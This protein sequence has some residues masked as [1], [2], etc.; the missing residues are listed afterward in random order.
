MKK[1]VIVIPTYNECKPIQGLLS[2]I[3]RLLPEV[4]VIVVDDNSPDKT[5]EKVKSLLVKYKH[6]HLISRKGKGGR[7][8]AVMT[9]FKHA[10]KHFKPD[11]YIEMDA[12]FSHEPKEIKNIISLSKENAVV[13]ASRYL[14]GSK[15]I[16]WPIKRHLAS[17]ISNLLVRLVLKLPLRDNTNGYRCYQRKAI[18]ILLGHQF[19]NQG[20]MVLSESAYLLYQ[21]GFKLVEIP[22]VFVSKYMEKSNA[23]IKEFLTAFSGL[24]KI[25]ENI[26]SKPTKD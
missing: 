3:F 6:L 2:T 24:L 10:F 9:G 21:K 18:K 12:D 8:S 4:R 15:I 20:Y 14:K 5:A 16:N 13:L 19:I 25:K 26:S 11:I 7:G 1:V 22:S 23:T 17:R